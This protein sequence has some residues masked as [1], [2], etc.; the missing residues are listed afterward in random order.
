M[1]RGWIQHG[2]RVRI[3]TYNCLAQSLAREFEGVDTE[4]LAWEKRLPRIVAKIITAVAG[5]LPFVI[6]L[7]EVD[8][9]CRD[10]LV[11]ALGAALRKN[12]DIQIRLVYEK[13]GGGVSFGQL[14]LWQRC[15]DLESLRSPPHSKILVYRD[16]ENAKQSQRG[17]LINFRTFTLAATHLKAGRSE[18]AARSAQMRQLL[19]AV[20]SFNVELCG[21]LLAERPLILAGDL[22][23]QIYSRTLDVAAAA[24]LSCVWMCDYKWTTWKRRAIT[25]AAPDVGEKK[26]IEDFILVRNAVV[27]AALAPPRDEGGCLPNENEPSDH[28]LLAA[29]ISF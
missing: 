2:S 15:I 21:N 29:D 27:T 4:S 1:E 20:A 11:E 10:S 14:V 5:D 19:T 7:Q 23:D 12:R 6:C 26:M 28:V 18:S 8:E 25:S 13:N 22:N 24:N 16:H 9:A 17:I 3:V